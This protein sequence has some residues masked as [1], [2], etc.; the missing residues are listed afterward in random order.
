M[1]NE[2]PMSQDPKYLYMCPQDMLLGVSSGLY[3][4]LED[5]DNHLHGINDMILK[6]EEWRALMQ[7]VRLQQIQKELHRMRKE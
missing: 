4:K 7:E 5:T 6:L 2:V 3:N 1:V